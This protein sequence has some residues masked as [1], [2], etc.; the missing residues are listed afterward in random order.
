VLFVAR[1]RKQLLKGNNAIS[2]VY[3]VHVMAHAAWG[4]ACLNAMLFERFTA[5]EFPSFLYS[6]YYDGPVGRRLRALQ[7]FGHSRLFKVTMIDC[8]MISYGGR[9]GR[10]LKATN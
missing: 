6:S 10:G 9:D 1:R 5:F 7:D 3:A 4:L 2:S 8:L